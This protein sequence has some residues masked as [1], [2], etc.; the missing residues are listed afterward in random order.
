MVQWVLSNL[1]GDHFQSN[2][3][4]SGSDLVPRAFPS[5]IFKMAACRE[6]TLAKA[7]SHGTKSPKILGDCYHV[8]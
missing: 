5:T 8:T 2:L 7:R 4:L 1:I 6:K 3:R